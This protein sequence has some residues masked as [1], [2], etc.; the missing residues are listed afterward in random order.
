[1]VPEPQNGSIKG[2]S[3]FQ[4]AKR[5]KLAANVSLIGASPCAIRYPL[6]FSPEPDVSM[7][8]RTLSLRIATST[9]YFAPL[10]FNH[11]FHYAF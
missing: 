2:V 9:G 8:S 10:S 3:P 4:F 5:T 11:P 6:R 1:M 7:V